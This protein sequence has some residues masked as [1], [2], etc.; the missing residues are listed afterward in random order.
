M[1]PQDLDDAALEARFTE[2][3]RKKHPY[4]PDPK[5][6]LRGKLT[7]AEAAELFEIARESVK[8]ETA[9]FL[10]RWNTLTPPALEMKHSQLD[11]TF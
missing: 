8:R 3:I 4:S 5:A 7:R 9:R 2:L 11:F 1:I 10:A 6:R